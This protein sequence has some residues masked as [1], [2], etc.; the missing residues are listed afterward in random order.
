M[1]DGHDTIQ[2]QTPTLYPTL[3]MIAAE[4]GAGPDIVWVLIIN[5][6]HTAL[7]GLDDPSVG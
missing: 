7:Y 1:A 5:D 6:E 3:T 4:E 2:L